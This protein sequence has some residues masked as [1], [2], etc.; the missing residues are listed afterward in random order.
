MKSPNAIPPTDST[1]LL[2]DKDV[3]QAEETR[4][5]VV[6][7]TGLIATGNIAS[8]ILGLMREIVLTNL[9][10]ASVAVDAFNIA[11]IVPKAFYDLLIGGHIN[12][13]LVPVLSETASKQTPREFWH[14]I[15]LLMSFTTVIITT[16]VLV[17]VGFAPSIVRIVAG[18][19]SP[20]TL[21]LAT[22]LLRITAP[23]LLFLSLFAIIS[24]TLYAIHVFA[25][26]AFAGAM[27]N[28][29]I[30]IA[31]L[32]AAPTL[33]IRATAIGWLLGSVAQV[34]LQLPGLSK[35]QLRITFQWR[36]PALI[37]MNVLY[38]PVLI[39]L[40]VD[41]MVIRF[42]SY[43]LANGVGEGSISYMNWATTLIQF[44]Q[45]LVATA[46]SI[47]ILPTLSLQAAR[48]LQTQRRHY[49]AA[50]KDT[51]GLG[52][53]LATSLI[54]PATIGLMVL[55]TPI[56]DLLFEHGQF[57]TV[58]TAITVMVL[59]LYLIG[60]PFAAIDLL[61]VYAF[62]ARQDTLTPAL[63]GLLSLGAYMIIAIGLIQPLG[64]YSLMIA[65]SV[66]H[67]IHASVCSYLLL[68]RLRGLGTQR[69]MKT[70]I[71]ASVASVIM[72]IVG[73]LWVYFVRDVQD[74]AT[75]FQEITN[76]MMG[77]SLCV[78]IFVGLA[79]WLNLTE[80]RWLVQYITQR[81]RTK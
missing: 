34:M 78:G 42:F 58:D 22:N 61:L 77:G 72:G 5:S 67:M 28:G 46:I 14:L 81:F 66:K 24:G 54:L 29:I 20:T 65:D 73:G 62:Y 57:N 33:G 71:R 79:Y 2:Q 16:L 76:L 64:L 45:G 6:Q 48:L 21:L 9:F 53:R 63:V 80:L 27:F 56:V 38:V 11:V 41:T 15:S 25:F 69:L 12:S 31:T 43:R 8:R 74:S 47:A 1:P 19:S 4:A 44:P 26:P 35:S 10:G 18:E 60:L 17:L 70:A 50:F 23:A 13:A 68:Y 3:T 52:L 51:L 32:V 36:H 30:V 49:E 59:R 39:S 7:A 37:Q 55:A 75:L 40:V